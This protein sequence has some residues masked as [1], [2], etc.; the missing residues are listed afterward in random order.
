MIRRR[1]MRL[2]K[3]EFLDIFKSIIMLKVSKGGY[4]KE[5]E[6]EF[7]KYIKTKY[8]IATCTGRNG[9]ELLLE[10]LGLQ[11]GDEVILPAYTLKDLVFLI[12]D[13]GFVPVLVDIKGD[14]FNID[15][16]LIQKAITPRTKVILATHIFGSPCMIEKIIEIAEKNNLV[17]IEDCAHAAGAE[18]NGQKVGSFGK[19]AFFSFE[20]IKPVNTFGGG[21]V[22]TNDAE[23][24]EYV[25]DEING[26]PY[27]SI[28][29]IFKIFYTY[30]E[31]FILHS[32][33]YLFVALLFKFEIFKRIISGIYLSIHKG[34]RINQ[35]RYSNLQGLIGLKQLKEL[36]KKNTLRRKK[37]KDLIAFLNEDVTIQKV[38]PHA[39]P[40]YYFFVAKTS[41]HFNQARKKLLSKGVDTSTGS[42]ITDDCSRIL[43]Q[44]GCSMVEKTH[45]HAIQLPLYEELKLRQIEYIADS[46]NSINGNRRI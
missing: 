4:V 37:A 34:S 21:M 33:I 45:M 9:L 1:R 40:V 12:K 14:T 8:A 6:K 39:K 19:A 28:K 10:A 25:K 38:I 46:V 20:T 17:I 13:R 22:T 29:V 16:E 27:K 23:I 11:E 18:Y 26:Y 43:S 15:P 32:P 44:H 36:D 24:A 3:G 35:F 41:L 7:A 2:Y 31:H 5:F 42:E 30:L